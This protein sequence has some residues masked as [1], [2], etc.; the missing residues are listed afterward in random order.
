MAKINVLE[1]TIPF[2]FGKYNRR[3]LELRQAKRL[4]GAIG[5]EG[6]RGYAWEHMLPLFLPNADCVES[7]G[8][9]KDVTATQNLKLLK[10]KDQAVTQL[11]FGSGQHR[12]AAARMSA[13]KI[14][15]RISE[16]TSAI[17][18]MQSG[19]ENTLR[20]ATITTL[21][22]ELAKENAKLEEVTFWGVKAFDESKH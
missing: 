17:K 14:K 22:G 12:V 21:E 8:L 10:I 15:K 5:S 11:V 3:P 13:T 20:V 16:I 4:A 19:P 7:E 18:K 1:P 2:F 6:N 9:I